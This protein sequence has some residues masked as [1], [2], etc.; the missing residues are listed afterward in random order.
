MSA[1]LPADEIFGAGRSA[2]QR[3]VASAVVPLLRI[4]H[5]L[6]VI[7]RRYVV[8][9]E[10]Q[11]VAIALWV[12]HTH[13][14]A[15]AEC[16]PYL[17]VTS[18]T[19][20]AGKTR[21]LEVLEPLVARPWL[22][23]RTSA[24]VLVR[25]TDNEH[26]TLL[27]D[28]SDAAFNGDR[29]YAEALRG[30]LNTGYRRSGRVSLCVGQGGKIEYRDFS[31]FG[32]KAIAGIGELP[33]TIADRSIRIKLRRRT[34]D[35][36]CARWRERDG[37]AEAAPIQGALCDWAAGDRRIEALRQ[38][39]PDLPVGLADRQADVWEPLLTIADLA[40]GD[41]P[42]R[43]RCAAVTLAGSIEDQDVVVDL[44][45]DIRDIL[46]Q[47]DVAIIPTKGLLEQLTARDDRPWATWR[48]D[49]PMTGRGLAKLIA[50]LGIFPV[51]L[52]RVR[53]YRRDAFDDAIA[54]YLPSQASSR[55]PTNEY[56]P[57]LAISMCQDRSAADASKMQKSSIKTGLTDGM[58]LRSRED[59]D[60]GRG[61]AP[62][63]W[64]LTPPPAG[65]APASAASVPAE[66]E[67]DEL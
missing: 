30:I 19:K 66:W 26:P 43:A 61:D 1:M 34:S 59:G 20:R 10:D 46:G 11:L 25:K 62:D 9:S 37:R 51:H 41:C 44:L 23:G 63:E 28:E 8:L 57:E 12:A 15:A 35:E 33:G 54:R 27:L 47:T 65:P 18:A 45:A 31:T 50:P 39:R 21:L 13:A 40:G 17:Q 6:M 24:A 3:P 29:E 16:T 60:Q 36:P 56:G 48:H 52:E 4:L 14:I 58:T 55:Q 53:G 5:D 2:D 32:C 38:A 7:I 49:K 64:S 67:E 42:A 22:T